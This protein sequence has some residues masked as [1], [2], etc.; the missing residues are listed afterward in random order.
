MVQIVIMVLG[1]HL[2]TFSLFGVKIVDHI[3]LHKP[4]EYG[5]F[6]GQIIGVDG[7]S[8]INT[9]VRW[10]YELRGLSYE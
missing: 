9:D 1:M 5:I 3:P 6:V 2:I 4:M 8:K 7:K 10:E